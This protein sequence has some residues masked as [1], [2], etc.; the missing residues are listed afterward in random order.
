MESFFRTGQEAAAGVMDEYYELNPDL[1]VRV[2]YALYL[3]VAY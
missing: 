3:A 1:K 2:A